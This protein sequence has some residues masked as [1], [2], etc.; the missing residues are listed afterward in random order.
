[1]SDTT[2]QQPPQAPPMPPMPNMGGLDPFQTI[3]IPGQSLTRAPGTYPFERPPQFVDPEEAF[4]ALLRSMTRERSA[5]EL[6][7]LLEIGVPVKAI[8]QTILQGGFM[9]GKWTVDV[10]LLLSQPL[11][12]LIFRM[13]RE[14]GIRPNLGVEP[15]GSDTLDR[16]VEKRLRDMRNNPPEDVEGLMVPRKRKDEEDSN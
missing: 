10:A 5:E 9:E 6:L 16:V 1:M 4:Q 8:V 3:P 12:A 15:R 11:T 2:S 7:N 14:A 13:A